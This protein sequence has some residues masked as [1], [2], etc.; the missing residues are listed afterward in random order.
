[1]AR[2]SEGHFMKPP[3][4]ERM[5]KPKAHP[6]INSVERDGRSNGGEVNEARG[7]ASMG[8]DQGSDRFGS[9]RHGG[10]EGDRKSF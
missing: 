1:M 8:D 2:F 4:D 9:H 3:V 6:M 10:P 5:F 7:D